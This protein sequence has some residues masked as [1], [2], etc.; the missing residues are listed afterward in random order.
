MNGI[1]IFIF[2]LINS[3]KINLAFKYHVQVFNSLHTI[4]SKKN[5]Q[6]NIVS[7]LLPYHVFIID[8]IFKKNINFRFMI[9]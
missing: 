6:N 4:E 7:Q 5:E 3:I 8:N 2:F 1:Y 9:N